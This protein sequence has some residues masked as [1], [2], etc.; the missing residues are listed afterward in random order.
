[1][2]SLLRPHF[3]ILAA[4]IAVLLGST[5]VLGQLSVTLVPSVPSPQL[6]GTTVTWTATASGG[7]GRYDYQFTTN[8][9]L[10]G[11]QIRRDYSN[12]RNFSWTPGTVEGTYTTGV[13]ARDRGAG[14]ST[15]TT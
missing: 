14:T 6:V 13:T 2:A 15:S 1:M 9:S 5:P 10:S 7:T 3:V 8:S 12:N 11:L 4:L